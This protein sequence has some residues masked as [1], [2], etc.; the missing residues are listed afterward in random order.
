MKGDLR[1]AVRTLARTPGFTVTAV[2]ALALGIGATTA[3]F[4][5]VNKVLLEPLPYPE[6]DRLVQLITTSDLGDQTIVSIQKFEVWRDFTGLFQH[7]AAYEIGSP[8]IRL[9]ERGFP[10][11]LNVARVSEGYFALFGA[12]VRTGR[13]FS[14]A[15]DRPGGGRVAV[16]SSALWRRRFGGDPGLVGRTIPLE[17]EAYKVVGVLESGSMMDRPADIWLPLQADARSLDHVSRVAVV[18]RL[19]PG[20]TLKDAQNA[21]HAT[22]DYFVRRYSPI[23]LLFRESFTAIPLRDAVVGDVRGP[24][25]FLIGAVA[26][27]LLISCANVANLVLARA[28]RRTREIAIRAALGA[29][30]RQIVRQ[31]LAE[32]ALLAFAGGAVGIAAGYL[33]VRGLL[34]ISPADIPR[35]GANGSAITVDWRVLL[36]TL[37]VSAFTGILFGLAPALKASRADVSSLVKDSASQSGMQLRRNLGVNLGV[38]LGRSAL[39]IAETALALVLLAGAGLLIRSFVATREIYRG[40]EERNVLTVQMSLASSQFEKTDQVAQLVRGVEQRLTSIR[41][42]SAV[43]STSALPLERSLT[44]PFTILGRDQRMVGRYHGTATW[45]SVSPGYFDALRIVLLRGRK[46]TEADGENAPGVVLINRAMLTKY[47]QEEGADPIGHFITIGKGMAGLEEPPR[48]IVGIVADVREA[49]LK[50]EPMMYVPVAQL[51]DRLTARN[52]RLLPITWVVRTADES[53]AVASAV[54]Q[55]LHWATGGLPLQPVRTMHDVVAA[56]SARNQFYAMLLAVFAGTALLLAAVGLYGLMAYSVQQ[57]TQEIGI[58]MALGAGPQDV[59][60]L[61]V[62]QGMRLALLGILA[63][64]PM[65][66]ALTRLM[67]SMIFGIRTWDPAVFAGVAA[68]MGSVAWLAAYLPS[69]R[70]TRVDPVE[71]LR[72]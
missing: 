46:F 35:I 23:L 47:W 27:V 51:P 69:I 70:A 25:Y 44:M 66:L 43:A 56:S 31:L 36:F 11:A 63:G 5:V 10:E 61:V 33:G 26:L 38:N 14:N 22:R 12:E 15:E 55:E 3:I 64:I 57:R 32:S 58:R 18:A 24:L 52:N 8:S 71:A 34:G 54:Q 17:H 29:E 45:R 59:R 30:R 60:N 19:K 49:G 21:M 42:V 65:G 40:F 7:I 6:P 9:T 1:Y 72:S 48:Q 13:T 41:G 37:A 20:F 28:T 2:A 50:R 68:L 16:I 53:S 4:S 62:W 39:V 67:D